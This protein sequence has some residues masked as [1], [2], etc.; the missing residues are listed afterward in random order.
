ML[1]TVDG[2]LKLNEQQDTL[3]YAEI[4]GGWLLKTYVMSE[5]SALGSGA[6]EAK[7]QN[8]AKFEKVSVGKPGALLLKEVADESKLQEIIREQEEQG[9]KLVLY[10]PVYVSG[11]ESKVAVFR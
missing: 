3:N 2:F 1:Y 6:A 4:A 9:R 10:S 8:N 5:R 7:P 11:A